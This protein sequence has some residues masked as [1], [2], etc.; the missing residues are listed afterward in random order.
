MENT[1]EERMLELIA[2]YRWEDIILR[3]VLV[4]MDLPEW[5]KF[6]Q[7]VPI[8]ELEHWLPIEV[9]TAMLRKQKGA[10]TPH[11]EVPRERPRKTTRRKTKTIQPG[12][13][14]RPAS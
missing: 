10:K 5:L 6:Q 12:T 3:N 4:E 2:V 14:T 7:G 11:P 9:V 13:T 1:E 8:E